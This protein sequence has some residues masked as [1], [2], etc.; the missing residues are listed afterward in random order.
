MH[1]GRELSEIEYSKGECSTVVTWQ[2][3]SSIEIIDELY[4][5]MKLAMLR[6]KHY[7][8]YEVLSKLVIM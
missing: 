5:N 3:F 6:G 1:V 7:M 4:E 8:L 2:K